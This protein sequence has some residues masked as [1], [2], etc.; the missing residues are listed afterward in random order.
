MKEDLYKKKEEDISILCSDKVMCPLHQFRLELARKCKKEQLAHTFGKFDGGSYVKSVDECLDTFRYSIVIENDISDYY[1]SERLTEWFHKRYLKRFVK[2]KESEE[3]L[4][5]LHRERELILQEL[6]RSHEKKRQESGLHFCVVLIQDN[7][8]IMM[9]KGLCHIFILNRRYN[10]RQIKRWEQFDDKGL[11]QGKIQRNLGLL[12]STNSFG[13]KLTKKDY[14]E[15]LFMD[16]KA[17]DWRL[18]KRLAEVWQDMT[19]LEKTESVG[20]VYIRTY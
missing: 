4:G 16:K 3:A 8:F 6:V 20:A 17:E 5:D 19:G 9:R 2:N 13:E 7:R 18:Q 12:L 1:F 11:C 10:T 15:A 14:K